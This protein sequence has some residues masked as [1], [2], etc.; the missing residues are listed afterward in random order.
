MDERQRD[1]ILQR[2]LEGVIR[3]EERLNAHLRYHSHKPH[4]IAAGAAVASAI[5]AAATIW[6]AR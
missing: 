6:L 2:V 4:W 1:S 5:L 3:V